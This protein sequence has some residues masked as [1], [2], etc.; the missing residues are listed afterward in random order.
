MNRTIISKVPIGKSGDWEV[1]KINVNK[2]EADWHNLRCSVKREERGRE[3]EVGEYTQLLRNNSTIMSDTPAELRDFD[4]FI[5]KAQ[6]HVL[7]T[8]LGL[9]LVTKAVCDKE[10]VK[11]VTVIEQSEDVFNLV[12]NHITSEKL[13]IIIADAYT[14]DPYPILK[15]LGIKKFDYMWH[16]IWDDICG[17]NIKMFVRMKDHYQPYMK[18]GKRQGFWAERECINQGMDGW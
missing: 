11:S 1:K 4:D 15:K 6:G 5:V 2:E 10:N 12:G 3:I 18:A 17:D 7:I 8:G 16:D 13:T 14:F 9:G